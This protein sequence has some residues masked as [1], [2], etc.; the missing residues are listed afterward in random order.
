MIIS[1]TFHLPQKFEKTIVSHEVRLPLALPLLYA[2]TR[3]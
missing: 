3:L 1:V 2:Y